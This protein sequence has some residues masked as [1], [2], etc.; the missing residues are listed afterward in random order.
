MF[1]GAALVLSPK[2]MRISEFVVQKE[3]GRVKTGRRLLRW[4]E[5]SRVDSNGESLRIFTDEAT[6]VPQ[7][8]IDDDQFDASLDKVIECIRDFRNRYR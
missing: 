3:N 4:P 7:I 2:G 5:I 8:E 1:S 6:D